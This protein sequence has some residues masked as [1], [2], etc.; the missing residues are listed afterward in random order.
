MSEAKPELIRLLKERAYRE[1]RFEL[2]SGRTSDYYIDAKLVTL[3]PRGVRLVGEAFREMLKP[4]DVAAIG[5][6]PLG[7]I[8]IV[9]AASLA[10]GVPGFIVRKDAKAYGLHKALEGPLPAAGSRMAM[11]EDVVTSGASV[12][13]AVQRVEDAGYRVAVVAAL[14]DRL[15]GGRQHIE[16]RGYAFESVA[17]V[18]E[19][20]G[21][22]ASTR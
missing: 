18:D 13:A 8:P 3:D 12:L 10:I 6:P 2:S 9:T 19:I 22:G 5:G 21:V 14:V 17:T 4:Y 20:K 16:G 1:G 7:A 11:V 15:Q